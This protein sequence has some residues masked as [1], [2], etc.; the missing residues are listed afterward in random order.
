VRLFVLRQPLAGHTHDEADETLY[1]LAGEATIN[2][3]E[4]RQNISAGSLSIVP[5]T[6]SHTVTPRGRNAVVMLSTISGPPCQ[7]R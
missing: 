3:G 6:V 4:Q 1:M 5:R 2:I 7:K